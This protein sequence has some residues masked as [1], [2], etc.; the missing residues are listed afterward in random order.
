MD[1]PVISS[2]F[3]GSLGLPRFQR[4]TASRNVGA[5]IAELLPVPLVLLAPD[6][7]VSDASGLGLTGWK[8]GLMWAKPC[9]FYSVILW[10]YHAING[11]RSIYIYIHGS[12]LHGYKLILTSLLVLMGISDY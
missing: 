1:F 11:V 8:P 5:A 12:I 7:T 4:S 3:P 10:G 9:H 2:S 6:R